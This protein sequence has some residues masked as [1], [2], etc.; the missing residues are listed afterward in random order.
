MK[1]QLLIAMIAGAGAGACTS[2]TGPGA[3]DPKPMEQLRADPEAQVQL[4]IP[5]GWHVDDAPGEIVMRDPDGDVAL[6]F[7]VVDAKDLGGALLEVGAHVLTEVDDVQLVGTPGDLTVNGMPGLY[8]DGKGTIDGVA[9][10][11]GVGVIDTPADKFL[12]VVGAA[13]SAHFAEHEGEVKEVLARIAP[14]HPS[15]DAQ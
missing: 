1:T 15:A 4:W 3:A 12:V 2:G 14:Y 11:L 10:D 6:R 5:P 8:Q 9:V 7:A 13:D